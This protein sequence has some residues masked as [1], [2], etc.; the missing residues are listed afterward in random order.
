MLP[1][2]RIGSAF[3]VV[4]AVLPLSS[5]K[6]RAAKLPRSAESAV[7]TA[8]LLDTDNDGIPDVWERLGF[9]ANGDG[10]IDVDLPAMGANPR[11]KDIFIEVDFMMQDVN[12]D[13]DALD[14]GEHTH[15]P[16]AAAIQQVI[17]AFANAPVKN[18]NGSTGITVHVDTGQLGGGNRI[19][20]FYE[21]DFNATS[22]GDRRDPAIGVGGGQVVLTWEDDR[23]RN[24]IGE[25]YLQTISLAGFLQGDEIVVNSVSAGQQLNPD[26]AVN[27]AGRMVVVWEDDQDG[28]GKYEILGVGFGPNLNQTLNLQEPNPVNSVSAG[29]QRRP[30]VAMDAAGNFVVVWEDDQ[31]GNGKYQIL[32][33]GF[34]ANGVPRFSLEEPNA[35]NSVSAGQQLRP[36]VAMDAAGNFVIVWEDDQD[37]NGRYEIL[38]RGFDANGTPRFSLQEPTPVNTVSGGQQLKPAVAMDG[39]GNFVVVWE[40]DQ[41][42]NGKY[43]V[44]GRGFD[45]NGNPRFSLEEPNA[46]NSVASGQQRQPAVAM[47]PATGRFTVSWEDDQDENGKYETLARGFDSNGGQRFADVVVN[48]VSTNNQV[49]PTVALDGAGNSFVAWEDGRANQGSEVFV[50][51]FDAAGATAHAELRGHGRGTNQTFYTIKANNFNWRR[52]GIFHYAIFAHN[53]L[54]SGSSGVAKRPGSDLIVSLGSFTSQ[55]GTVLD[56]AGTLMHELGH[57]LSLYHGGDEDVNNKPNYNSVMNYDYQLTGIDTNCDAAGDGV[58]DY[59][60]GRLPPLREWQLNETSGMCDGTIVVNSVSAGQ[61]FTPSVAAAANGNFVV[62]WADDQDQNGKYEILARGFDI[63]GAERFSLEEPTGVNSVSSGQQFVPVVA[64]DAAGNF[65]VVWEDDQDENGKFQ[66]LARGF[67]ANGTPRFSLEEPNA[68][69]S[70]SA[71]QQV[72]PEVAMDATGNFVVVWED[73]QDGNGRYEILARGFNANGAPRFSLQEPTPV[74][75]VSAGQQLRPS[76]AMDATGNF[77]IVWEDDQDGNGKYQILG[78]GFNANGTPRFSLEEPNA[79]NSVSAGQQYVARVAM[80]QVGNFAV[81]WEDDQDANGYY[82]ILARGFTAAGAPRFSLQEPTPVNSVSSGQQL[83]PAVAMAPGGR[84]V[85]VWEDDQDQNGKYQILAR[86][87]LA[88]GAAAFSLEEPNAVNADASG[89]QFKPRVALDGTGRI[90]AVWEDDADG[91]GWYQITG[92]VFGANGVV[93]NAV[94]I[95]WDRDG[96]LETTVSVDLSDDG[97][98]TTLTDVADW[99]IVR[100]VM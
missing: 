54:F 99:K 1:N 10:V 73:D 72:N 16:V 68:V 26:L 5:V 84:F 11:R 35:V 57:N 61:Q 85:L 93:L 42:G 2:W 56:Q 95:D 9:D 36:D 40:D 32:A 44:L 37:G 12:G 80:D 47:D 96:V 29:Q 100:L 66:I 94:P 43:Q 14:A 25:I 88:T 45:S 81:V 90:I 67:T 53:Q 71:G 63:T 24:G 74:N 62:V 78:R 50:R 97:S 15:Q 18:P 17:A 86:G 33:R 49:D 87:F 30:A 64:M 55:V 83:N 46:V 34:D 7:S 76:V 31:D 39:A 38:A 28:N 69:N 82:E 19:S 77:V 92:R 58:L 6:E 4:F 65:V 91:N 75:T 27:G 98:L 52:A 51:G 60:R 79:V 8:A 13:G 22:S 89:Q 41:D 48:T 23:D 3:A 59:S 20:H 70:V 21:L